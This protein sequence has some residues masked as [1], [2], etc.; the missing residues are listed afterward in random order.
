MIEN[1]KKSRKMTKKETVKKD[2]DFGELEKRNEKIR[3]ELKYHVKIH[4]ESVKL[5]ESVSGLN[6][7]KKILFNI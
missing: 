4:K 7:S 5:V 1:K 3:R 2:I 6:F